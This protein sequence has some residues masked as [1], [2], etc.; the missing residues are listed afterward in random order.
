MA[1]RSQRQPTSSFQMRPWQQGE[2]SSQAGGGA[3][4]PLSNFRGRRVG[5]P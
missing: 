3:D 5:P 1:D 4:W 2:V